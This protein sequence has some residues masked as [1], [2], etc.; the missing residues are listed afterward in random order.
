LIIYQDGWLAHAA[1]LMKGIGVSCG[2]TAMLKNHMDRRY[3]TNPDPSSGRLREKITGG[4][5]SRRFSSAVTLRL[6]THSSGDDPQAYVTRRLDE[7][8][9]EKILFE[10]LNASDSLTI[11]TEYSRYSFLILDPVQRVGILTGGRLRR[12]MAR[13]TLV[14]MIEDDD[15]SRRDESS[16]RVGAQALFHLKS[17][18]GIRRITTSVV[19]NIIH[20]KSVAR[21][22]SESDGDEQNDFQNIEHDLGSS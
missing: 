10:D 1:G 12:S 14:G 13:A 19:T 7:S 17:Q 11:H 15:E 18:Q 20:E 6:D 5:L 22:G 16:L 8:A 21:A 3:S 9:N 4:R 2:A